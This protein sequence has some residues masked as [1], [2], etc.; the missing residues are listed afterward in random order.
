[1]GELRSMM[2]LEK[3]KKDL[4]K[5]AENIRIEMAS[6]ERLMRDT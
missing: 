6:L 1:L 5:E 3:E 4:L 2:K